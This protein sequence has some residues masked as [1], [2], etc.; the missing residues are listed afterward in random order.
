M[1]ESRRAHHTHSL[2]HRIKIQIYR[3]NKKRTL[4]KG[5]NVE[6]RSCVKET[7][8]SSNYIRIKNEKHFC[9]KNLTRNIPAMPHS[10]QERTHTTTLTFT[11]IH[12]THMHRE[13]KISLISQ[14]RTCAAAVAANPTPSII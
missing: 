9:S 12:Y 10:Q 11:P 4:F 5:C 2:S 3:V 7:N 13:I 14:L 6:E 1:E 8:Y